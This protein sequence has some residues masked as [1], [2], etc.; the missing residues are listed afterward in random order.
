MLLS[1][2]SWSYINVSKFHRIKEISMLKLQATSKLQITSR[3]WQN[4]LI[5]HLT[6]ST[7][8]THQTRPLWWTCWS[9]RSSRVSPTS[10]SSSPSP[11]ATGGASSLS[12]STTGW[13]CS[14]S[15][16]CRGSGAPARWSPSPG[17]IS[18]RRLMSEPQHLVFLHNNSSPRWKID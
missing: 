9:W 7:W 11:S 1:S 5:N 13:S 2:R 4:L 12:T 17:W 16:R 18:A 14:G 6:C 10:S 3:R 8:R 15:A